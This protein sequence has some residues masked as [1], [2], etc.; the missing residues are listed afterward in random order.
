M[1]GY[2]KSSQNIDPVAAAR[3]VAAL[4]EAD[5]EAD[6]LVRGLAVRTGGGLAVPG[7]L[8]LA[9]PRRESVLDWL[10]AEGFSVVARS[11]CVIRLSHPS[12]RPAQI[13][14]LCASLR[15]PGLELDPN[16]I[17]VAAAVGKFA[18]AGPLPTA[19]LPAR[20][21]AGEGRGIR[22]AVVDVTETSEGGVLGSAAGHAT[23]AAGLVRDLAPGA[24][25]RVVAAL[26][27]D[28]IGSDFDVARALFGLAASEEPPALINLSL[29]AYAGAAPVAMTAALGE[30]A[31][32]HPGVLVVAA[33]GNDG[34]IEPVWPAAAK[35]VIAV[36]S[37]AAYSNHGWW[38]DFSIAAEGIVGAFPRGVRETPDGG[39]VEY[40]DGHAAATGTSF[41][42]PQVTGLLAALLGR[43]LTPV[44][45]VRA[46]RRHA[47]ALSATR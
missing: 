30:L 28:G 46:L 27:A 39:L 4:A 7:E 23:F 6:L 20:V 24:D 43:G 13:E 3:Q 5:T 1:T 11:G 32:R 2:L 21:P 16:Y 25:V 38:V 22:V 17:V 40:R 36:G 47:D 37:P 15:G 35:T 8:L 18:K 45:A 33:A 12:A 14:R 19:S 10:A 34:R 31:V 42:A 29:A 26:D 41:A 9:G 44:E